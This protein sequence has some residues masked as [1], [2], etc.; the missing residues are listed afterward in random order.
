MKRLRR[1]SP[2]TTIACLALFFAVAGGSAVALQG[3]NSVDSGDIKKGNV[4]TSDIRNNAVTTKKIRNNHVRAADIQENAV[5]TGE[6]RDGQV[7]PADLTPDELFRKIGAPGQPAFGN[8]GESDCLWMELVDPTLGDPFNEP[9]FYKDAHGIV[10]VTG[11]VRSINGFGGDATCDDTQD[12]FV[13]T[14]PPG[15]RPPE[16]VAFATLNDAAW[17]VVGEQDIVTP[18]ATLPAG[19]VAYSGAGGPTQAVLDDIAFRATAGSGLPRRGGTVH[20][21]ETQAEMLGLE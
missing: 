15:Y 11:G 18:T 19:T 12:A 17:L 21:S 9:S 5:G 8:G 16:I 7:G 2:A 14:L 6:I 20:I 4:K 10:R 3:R 1:P 13:F